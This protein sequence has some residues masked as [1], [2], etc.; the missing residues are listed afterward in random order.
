MGRLCYP[1]RATRALT[2]PAGLPSR[3]AARASS[4]VGTC[5]H[6]VQP[7]ARQLD[8]QGIGGGLHGCAASGL[9]AAT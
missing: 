1:A 2:S 8:Y 4:A 3:Q 9:L 7:A 5:A 6:R